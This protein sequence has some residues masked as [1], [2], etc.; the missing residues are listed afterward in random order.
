MPAG[1]TEQSIRIDA[2]FPEV[3]EQTNDVAAWPGLF[4]EYATADILRTE[5]NTVTFR[6]TMHPDEN[7][8][9]WS[10]VSERTADR[11]TGVVRARRVETG[12]F[13]FMNIEWTYQDLAGGGVELL[14]RQ[15][16]A[17]KPQAPVDTDWMTANIGVNSA[18]QLALIR[19]RVQERARVRAP[20]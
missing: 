14:W 7:G 13:A 5:G 15:E 19:E 6:L 2:P 1:R 8:K 12:P 20:R 11:A 4:S 9:V 3:W 18:Q 16:F 10:W 17:M